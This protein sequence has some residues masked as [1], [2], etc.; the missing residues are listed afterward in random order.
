MDGVDGEGEVLQSGAPLVVLVFVVAS[1]I[2]DV[3]GR[4]G[5]EIDLQGGVRKQVMCT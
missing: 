1:I 4:W 3:K 5:S 2:W